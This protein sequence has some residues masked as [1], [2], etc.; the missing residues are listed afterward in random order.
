[1]H[2]LAAVVTQ[3]QRPVVIEPARNHATDA[4]IDFIE[5]LLDIN[6]DLIVQQ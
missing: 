4:E 1:M 2:S 3:S 5:G 6:K